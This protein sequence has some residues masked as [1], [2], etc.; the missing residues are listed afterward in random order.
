MHDFPKK[1]H[2]ILFGETE[3]YAQFKSNT[4]DL[5]LLNPEYQHTLWDEES[6]ESLMKEKY[7]QYINFYSKLSV[8]EKTD[9]FRY[10]LMYEHGGIYFDLDMEFHR[11]LNYFFTNTHIYFRN[12]RGTDT[13]PNVSTAE[14]FNPYKYDIIVN[15][16]N[17]EREGVSY[18]NNFCLISKAKQN[19]WLSLLDMICLKPENANVYQKT[20]CVVLTEALKTFKPNCLILPPF[21]FGWGDYMKTPRPNWTITSHLTEKNGKPKSIPIIPKWDDVIGVT[22]V[23]PKYQHLVEPAITQFKKHTK[24]NVVVLYASDESAFSQK[25]NLDLLIGPRKIIYFD[26]DLWFIRDFDFSK[27]VTNGKFNA[28]PDPMAM[29]PEMDSGP[30]PFPFADSRR[31]GWDHDSYINSGL[32][33]CD[34]ANPDIRLIFSDARQALEDC[35]AGK[36]ETPV[37]WTDQYYFNHALQKR[38]HLLNPLDFKFNFFKFAVDWGGY[39]YIPRDVVGLHAAGVPLAHKLKALQIQSRVLSSHKS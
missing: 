14:N 27:L 13:L 4:R 3:K 19:F 16:E 10:I 22:I 7:G 5:K 24:L 12:V 21:Y 31:E 29:V 35:H 25:L 8:L 2:Q 18:V 1:I 39:P 34:L 9:F 36:I 30:P 26:V 6:A 28:V 32:F 33:V 38:L 17:Y 11:P 20:G 23:S 15:A 37:D